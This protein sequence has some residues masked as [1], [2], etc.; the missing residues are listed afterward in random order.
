MSKYWW[1][2]SFLVV[3]PLLIAFALAGSAES[4]PR[5]SYPR[6]VKARAVWKVFPC[7]GYWVM[8][9]RTKPDTTG[10]RPVMEL[11]PGSINWIKTVVRDTSAIARID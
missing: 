8:D 9:P 1:V 11:P 6:E 2:M 10:A 3:Y 4:A 7:G 5:K